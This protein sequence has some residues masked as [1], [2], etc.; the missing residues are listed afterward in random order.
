M[1]VI[2]TNVTVADY[3]IDLDRNEVIVNR[4][5]Q[6]SD[7]VWPDPAKSF[8]IESLLLGYPI[9]KLSLFQRLDVTTRK[10]VKE[11][12]D[13]QQRSLAILAF[14]RDAFALGKALETEELRGLTYSEL[15]DEYK[16]RFLNYSLSTDVF[17]GAT[18]EMIRETF[19]RMNSYTVPLNPEEERH[20]TFQGLFKWFVYHTSRRWESTL[21][22]AGVFGEKQFIRMADAKLLSEVCHALLYGISTTNKKK[23]NKLYKDFDQS[24]PMEGEVSRQ[25][26]EAFTLL[27]EMEDIH[28]TALAKHY[29][30]YSLA[31]AVVHIRRPVAALE[32]V[33][34]NQRSRRIK[35]AQAVSGL[36]RLS[37]A[38]ESSDETGPY[39]E[40]VLASS[41]KT[42]VLA[43]RATRFK[44]FCRALLGEIAQ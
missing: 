34:A 18:P 1:D 9:P 16:E 24:F 25:F 13:G 19:R 42:N 26:D 14:Y 35:R 7:Q 44:W 30:I 39:G 6:R 41:N 28:G 3:C 5:Y 23:L 33:F 31:L 22:E 37:D 36:L 15:P 17:V 10:V 29:M 20:A 2:S 4:Q 27:G 32:P 11:I 38:V 21:A 12:V 43:Q 40:F 8:L